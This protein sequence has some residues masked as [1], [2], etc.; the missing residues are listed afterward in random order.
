[1]TEKTMSGEMPVQF[2]C[3]LKGEMA[4]RFNRIKNKYGLESNADMV[5]LLITMEYERLSQIKKEP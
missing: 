1:M 4:M 3:A 5:R 2:R